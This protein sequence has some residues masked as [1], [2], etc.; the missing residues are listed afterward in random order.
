MWLLV[1]LAVGAVAAGGWF[2]L[3]WPFNPPVKHN[4]VVMVIDTLRRDA[5]GCYGN[6][7]GLS[8]RIDAIAAEGIR[9]DRAISTSG[10]TLPAVASLLT[11]AWPT[12]HGGLGK[13]TALTPIRDELPTAAECFRES[14]FNTLGVANA[15]FVSPLLHLDRG[16]D[17]YDHRHAYNWEI[18]RA[19][20]S[21]DTA[22]RLMRAHQEESNFVFIHLFDPHLDYDPP[23]G[24]VTKFTGGRQEPAPPL[25]MKM[26]LAMEGNDGDQ[27]PAP[28]D[29]DYVEGVYYGEV[30]FVDVHVGRLVDELKAMG[31]YERTT[32][33]I[34]ADHGEEFWEHNG[35][36]HGHT[37]YDELIRIPLIMKL[38]AA[39]RPVKGVISGQVRLLDVMPT[40]F[41][42]LGMETPPSF[43][44][45]SLMPFVMG[46]QQE[47]LIA[48]SE[49]TLYKG[50][51][52]SWRTDR[53]KYVYDLNPQGEQQAELYD[54]RSDPAETQ[55]II[56]EQPQIAA[57]LH[58]QLIQFYE[59]LKAQTQTMSHPAV[60]NMSPKV[61]ESLRSL[62]YIR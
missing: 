10:W 56:E 20:E 37:L 35:F 6:P 34:T 7:R 44:G 22:L 9:F 52:L 2:A 19:D 49:S 27:P 23:P 42:L 17:V 32:L 3:R 43:V 33:I 41:D 55:N 60:V 51:K 53:Y 59:Q 45:R 13:K 5:L 11:G 18:R 8:P 30:N 54:W 62:G 48:F 25:S 12:V 29:V 4:V 61:I 39:V 58:Q 36:E 38:P 47:D 21:I 28:Q 26:C 24:Y 46:Q 57:E 14:G 31:M 40:V 50:D 15:A 1:V 16:F